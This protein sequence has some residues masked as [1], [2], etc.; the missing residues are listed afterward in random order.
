MNR[1]ERR[2]GHKGGHSLSTSQALPAAPGGEAHDPL[3]LHAQGVEAYSAGRLQDAS[4]LIARAIAADG[5]MPSFHYNLAIVLKAQGKLKEAA[6]A[7][8]RAIA[9]KPDY[10]DAHNNLGNVWKELG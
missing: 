6:A 3:T 9:L 1:K 10:G 5:R 7:Y 8:S 2:A 4:S